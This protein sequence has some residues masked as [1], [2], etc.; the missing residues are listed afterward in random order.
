MHVRLGYAVAMAFWSLASM[1]HVIGSSLFSSAIRPPA[2]LGEFG[3][4]PASITTVALIHL[5]RHRLAPARLE[6]A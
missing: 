1:G 5:F 2:E 4:F 3:V 6:H